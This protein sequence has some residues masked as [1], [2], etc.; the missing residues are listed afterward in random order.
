MQSKLVTVVR[1][2]NLF[3]SEDLSQRQNERWVT[4]LYLVLLV[5]T[6]VI[7][8]TYTFVVE[9]TTII[10][11]QRPT[12]K[13]YE[14]LH[15]RQEELHCPCTRISI[16]YSDFTQINPTY[17]QICSSDFTTTQWI[18]YLFGDTD[19]SNPYLFAAP[20]SDSSADALSIYDQL[21]FRTLSIP[22]FYFLAQLCQFS[23]EIIQTAIVDF[24]KRTFIHS[25]LISLSTLTF[26]FR[27]IFDE[28]RSQVPLGIL[29]QH[30]LIIGLTQADA[31][32][33]N[34]ETNWVYHAS[35]TGSGFNRESVVYVSPRH[36]NECSCGT[37]SACKELSAM[38]S[39]NGTILM[40]IPGLYVGC[41]PS[42]ALLQSS[43]ECFYNQSCIDQILSHINYNRDSLTFKPLNMSAP[44][45]YPPQTAIE[46]MFTNLFVE[47]WNSEVSHEKYYH[48]C[49]P[50]LCRYQYI[51]RFSLNSLTKLTGLVGGLNLAFR[52]ITPVIVKLFLLGKHKFIGIKNTILRARVGI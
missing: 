42:Q 38:R 7:L 32:Q 34:Y 51:E 49:E 44:S 15:T 11:I 43:M 50:V 48:Q 35:Q 12:L 28:F 25:Q 52:L 19:Y 3:K 23:E 39:K 20:F 24:G 22:Q 30:E 13:Q 21:D 41:L 47:Q 37:S 17:H 33:S 40:T 46:E 26:E 8:I 10:T 14:Q 45:Q 6:S 4:R 18:G 31:L 5:L 2:L 16:P 1:E 29:R 36:F 27:K 9:Q